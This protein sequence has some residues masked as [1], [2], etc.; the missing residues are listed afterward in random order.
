MKIRFSLRS[1]TKFLASGCVP[2][3]RLFFA[4]VL[5]LGL[6]LPAHAD[7]TIK[8][9]TG[10]KGLGI[11]GTAS[12]ATFIKGHKMRTDATMGGTMQTTIFDVDAQKMYIFDSKKK[13]A[14]VWDMTTFGAEL[15]KS[16]D[17][18]GAKASVK[19]N[20]QTKQIGAHPAAGYDVEISM[21]SAMAGSKDM[22]MTVTLSG[23]IWIVKNAPGSAD[24]ARFYKAA[25]DKGWIFSD[26]RSA[27]AQPGQAKA[28]AEMYKQMA[29]IGGIPYETAVQIRMSGTGPMAAIMSKM[30][31]VTMTSTVDSVEV[32]PLADDLFA[33]PAG[34]KLN[35]KK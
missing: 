8:Q 20:G 35:Q 34:Y 9:T 13:Q 32:A 33:P 21:Q 1:S 10:G 22:A 2:F 15:A 4:T 5:S 16:V 25:V 3:E 31:T 19:P 30:G 29:E 7:V 12:G 27:K 28:M 17:L 11:S 14:D 24:Y 18:S 26:P 23:P 6:A